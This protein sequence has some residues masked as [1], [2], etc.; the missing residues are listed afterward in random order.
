[1][2]VG[3]SEVGVSVAG[4]EVITVG[5]YVNPDIVGASVEGLLGVTVGL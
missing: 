1:M 2:L 3:A 4:A 5:A